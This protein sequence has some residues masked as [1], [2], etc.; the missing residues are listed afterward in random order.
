[1]IAFANEYLVDFNGSAAAIRAGYGVK[2]AKVTASRL[3][4]DPKIQSYLG[5]LKKPLAAVLEITKERTMRE[6][7]RIA[8]SDP[9]KLFDE[10]SRFK[11][12]Q[13]LDDDAAATLASVEIDALYAM[14]MDGKVQVGDTQK[15]K[16]FD[17]NRALDMLAKHFK[18]Y[19]TPAAPPI[20]I[21]INNL[22]P[23]QLKQ[24]LEIKRAAVS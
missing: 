8:F 7:A 3:L 20:N 2:S 15:V 18:I 12:I 23:A 17:K 19:E 21:N 10:N 13:D 14:T 6:I 22:S 24:L 4:A 1:M 11:A 5:V 16:V 9:R